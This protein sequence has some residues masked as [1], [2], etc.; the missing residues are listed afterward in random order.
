MST[1]VLVLLSARVLFVVHV[2]S[3][4][5]VRERG[6]DIAVLVVVLRSVEQSW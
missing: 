6:R 2:Y 3:S 5:R 4:V 1:H